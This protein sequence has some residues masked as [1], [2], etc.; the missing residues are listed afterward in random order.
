MVSVGF[1]SIATTLVIV[2]MPVSLTLRLGQI[3]ALIAFLVAFDA[4]LLTR[5]SRFGGIASGLA[6]AI[7]VTPA[8]MI[9]ALLVMNRRADA[10]RAAL[11]AV[12]VTGL[13][14]LVA[15]GDSWA[16]FTGALFDTRRV[17]HGGD[18]NGSLRR[19][20]GSLHETDAPW[21]VAGV[22]VLVLLIAGLGVRRAA[23]RND[24]TE[25]VTITMLCTYVLSPITWGHHVFFCGPAVYL[26]WTRRDPFS[27][28]LALAGALVLLDPFEGGEGHVYSMWRL[29]FM[30]AAVVRA[31]G[32]DSTPRPRTRRGARR[33]AGDDRSVRRQRRHA[34]V[35]GVAFG[36]IVGSADRQLAQRVLGDEPREREGDEA[37][38]HRE[39][40]HV[41]QRVG[42]ALDHV[43]AQDRLE[44]ADL[45][46]LSRNVSALEPLPAAS[47]A[48]WL[49]SC[50]MKTA[51]KMA[52]PSVLPSE[53][54]KLIADVAMP[55]SSCATLFWTPTSTTMNTNP[56]PTPIEE[57]E[58][59]GL[60]LAGGA[61]H[62]REHDRREAH[63]RAADDGVPAVAPGAS[64]PPA[65]ERRAAEHADRHRDD[66]QAGVG[67]LL[68]DDDLE[69]ERAVDGDDEHRRAGEEHDGSAHGE[70]AFAEQAQR[71]DRFGARRSCTMNRTSD[72]TANRAND[73]VLVLSQPQSLPSCKTSNA[74]TT[75]MMSNVAPT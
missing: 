45:V 16:Y 47:R 21:V 1:A 3:N 39:E 32:D 71:K 23:L 72:T 69:E 62:R 22:G 74:A 40:E 50:A 61:V 11:T 24:M 19:L 27:A 58:R 49:S 29:V 54:K 46:G 17:G 38:R 20:I 7:K 63:E 67:R 25:A 48:S 14:A 64:Q 73:S 31:D 65:T 59:R 8:L 52:V 6:A 36:L 42:E 12:V 51:P 41:V 9:P 18:F 10:A 34:A 4:V 56:A 5:R 75:H 35:G 2:S 70:D 60:E 44:L 57:H 13:A 53:R 68:P 37:E 43:V 66:E 28:A 30:V 26:L 15:P 55:R 33:R